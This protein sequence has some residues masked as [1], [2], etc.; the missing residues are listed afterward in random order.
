MLRFPYLPLLA[1]LAA[2]C[3]GD[4]LG[5]GP[6][7]NRAPG[8]PP[9]IG[10]SASS[11][12]LTSS[13]RMW[14]AE[15][16]FRFTNQS[17]RPISLLN[18]HGWSGAMLEKW[19]GGEWVAGW[20]PVLLAC[21]SRPIVIRAGGTRADVLRI[22]A[23]QPGSNAYPQFMVPEVAGTYRLVIGGAFWNYDHGG[24]PWGE[25]PPLE[26][27]VSDPFEIRTE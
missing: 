16:P 24:P 3:S 19:E 7:F 4:F 2:G 6:N 18:C 10:T 25:P 22:V 20:S 11:Y 8:D 1:V 5:T 9:P 15:I 14:S 13:G 27:R 23:G 26:L 17:N 12:T 21:L